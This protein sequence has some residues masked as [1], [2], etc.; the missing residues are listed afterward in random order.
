MP[1]KKVQQKKGVRVLKQATKHPSSMQHQSSDEEEDL[2]TIHALV[3]RVE[4]LER[5]R[6]QTQ[7]VDAG[8]SSGPVGKK[9]ARL[10]SKMTKSHLLDD[11][12]SRVGVLEDAM[13]MEGSSV[14]TPPVGLLAVP[15]TNLT[16]PELERR[17]VQMPVHSTPATFTPG[18]PGFTMPPVIASP[19]T[20]TGLLSIPIPV[21]IALCGHSILF[22]AHRRASS[23]A[24]GTQLQLSATATVHWVARRGMLWDAFLPSVCRIMS[25]MDRPHIL[26]I[27]LGENDLVQSPG[28]DLLLKVT[29]DLTWLLNSYPRLIIVWSDMLVR[30]VWRGAI[31]PNRID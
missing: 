19:A 17:D 13:P 21:R 3:A 24:P 29:R 10:A 27:H 7:D 4:A 16:L 9:S 11:L 28:V 31:H 5:E 26:L 18:S 25:S 2:G 30:R 8:P 14:H 12:V 1:P 15:P 22:W 20:Y 23:S 6:R